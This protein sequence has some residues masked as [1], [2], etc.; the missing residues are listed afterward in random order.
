MTETKRDEHKRLQDRTDALKKEHA[1]LS[2]DRAP[3]D[4]ADHDEHTEHLRKHKDDL[5]KHQR[6]E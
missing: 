4:Q 6:R 2:R 1:G 3:F 5:A